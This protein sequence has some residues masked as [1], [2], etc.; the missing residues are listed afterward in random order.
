MRLVHLLAGI[1]LLPQ[2]SKATGHDTVL[3]STHPGQG[4]VEMMLEFLDVRYPGHDTSGDILYVSVRRQQLFLVKQGRLHAVYPVATAAKGLSTTRDSQGTPTGLH[5]IRTKVG[6]GVPPFGILRERR[7][8]GHLADKSD[9]HTSGDLITSRILWLDGLEPGHNRGGSMDSGMRYIYIHGT[10]DEASVGRPSSHGCIRM[11]NADV[12]D[13]YD[14]VAVG[15]L[16]VVL[17]N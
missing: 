12:I 9:A 17:D 8:T 7:F 4:L 1:A 13:L 3:V 10:A 6:D 5:R 11:R 14:Q 2:W 16:V 15:A